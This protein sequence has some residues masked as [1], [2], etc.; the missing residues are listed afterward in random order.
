MCDLVIKQFDVT[1]KLCLLCAVASG[2]LVEASE[3]RTHEMFAFELTRHCREKLTEVHIASSVTKYWWMTKAMHT[4]LSSM[5]D[6]Y[7]QHQWH[8]AQRTLWCSEFHDSIIAGVKHGLTVTNNVVILNLDKYVLFYLW[9][10]IHWW[11][12]EVWLVVMPP[13]CGST[14]CWVS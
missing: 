3:Y 8:A 2:M 14:F 13:F 7:L 12:L 4:T 6:V 9:Y 5:L 1:N 10:C 11:V